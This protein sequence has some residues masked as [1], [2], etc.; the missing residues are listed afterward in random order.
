MGLYYHH[1]IL[2]IIR[3]LKYYSNFNNVSVFK[4]I[5]DNSIDLLLFDQYNQVF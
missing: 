1:D 4:E 3:N 5:M 2:N